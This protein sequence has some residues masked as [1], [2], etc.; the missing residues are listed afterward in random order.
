MFSKGPIHLVD[1]DVQMGNGKILSRQII[2]HPGS[3][4]IIPRN[5]KG[6]IGLVR[7]FRF[8]AEKWLWEFPA[9]GV[10]KNESL[11]EAAQRELAEETGYHPNKL[12]KVISFF[13]TPGISG[14]LMHL[15][16]AEDLVYAP[17][18]Q[19]EDED[20]EVKYFGIKQLEQMI[21]KQEILDAKTILGFT[22][23]KM[24]GTFE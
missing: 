1:C 11:P 7:Q 6:E 12:K 21:R 20:I 3:I 14:E 10:E 5:A 19:D 18:E 9:G 13:P 23:L 17:L 15:F 4:V 22:Y 2:E 16:L 8:A 24:V